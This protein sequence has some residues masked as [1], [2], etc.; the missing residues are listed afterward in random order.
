M[1]KTMGNQT[2][3]LAVAHS[4]IDKTG[5]SIDQYITESGGIEITKLVSD[6]Q[7]HNIIDNEQAK[8][9]LNPFS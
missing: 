8:I 6:L 7:E 4:L 2:D 9:L 5:V 1:G 3:I